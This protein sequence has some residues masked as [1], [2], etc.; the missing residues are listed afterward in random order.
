MR[1]HQASGQR[2]HTLTVLKVVAVGDER[3]AQIQ[4]L[5]PHHVHDLH[6][7]FPALGTVHAAHSHRGPASR[8][9]AMSG[10]SPGTG[11]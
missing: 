1:N 7:H 5:A 2:G 11:G 10:K 3:E 8:S 6:G 9:H 4:A